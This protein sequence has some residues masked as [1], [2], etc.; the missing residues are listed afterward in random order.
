MAPPPAKIFEVV[1]LMREIFLLLGFKDHVRS[2]VIVQ[3]FFHRI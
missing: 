2:V 1:D 3:I